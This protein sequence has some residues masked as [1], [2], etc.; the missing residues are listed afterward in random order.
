MSR[1]QFQKII[2]E[3]FNSSMT[4]FICIFQQFYSSLVVHF[5]SSNTFNSLCSSSIQVPIWFSKLDT[6]GDVEIM[7]ICF[8]HLPPWLPLVYV[9]IKLLQKRFTIRSMRDS[10][11]RT[12]KWD[13]SNVIRLKCWTCWRVPICKVVYFL[14][15]YYTLILMGF[16]VFLFSFQLSIITN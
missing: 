2:D 11:A 8:E 7:N 5:R 14:A 3:P 16:L 13:V 10:W 12:K 15:D 1:G 9:T 4:V 6:S